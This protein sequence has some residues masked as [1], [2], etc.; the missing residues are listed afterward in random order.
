MLRLTGQKAD[1]LVIDNGVGTFILMSDDLAAIEQFT[2]EV[3]PA[4]RETVGREVPEVFFA[5]NIRSAAVRAK[6]REGI[7]YDTVPQSL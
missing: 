4:L 7:S 3:A 1:G 5:P 2:R 6:R